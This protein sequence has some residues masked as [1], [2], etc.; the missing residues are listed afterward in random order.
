MRRFLALYINEMIKLTHRVLTL[1]GLAALVLVTL[2]VFLV[3][4]NSNGG[5]TD[6]DVSSTA[7]L[8]YANLQLAAIEAEFEQMSNEGIDEPT[9]YDPW[10]WIMRERARLKVERAR[11]LRD[12]DPGQFKYVYILKL[13]DGYSLNSAAIHVYNELEDLSAEDAMMR[14][15]MTHTLAYVGAASA[16]ELE[17]RALTAEKALDDGTF[18][19]YLDYNFLFDSGSDFGRSELRAVYQEIWEAAEVD[20]AI[21]KDQDRFEMLERRIS[22]Y[23]VRINGLMFG[24]DERGW[25]SVPLW[26]L[27][28]PQF[29]VERDVLRYQIENPN[30]LDAQN[31]FTDI[32]DMT[33]AGQTY[34]GA[35]ISMYFVLFIG[36]MILSASSLSQEIETGTI[37]A[38]ILSPVKRYKIVLAKLFALLTLAFALG[39]LT[40]FCMQ[41][42]S[43]ILFGPSSLPALV[44]GFGN[45]IF[46]IAQPFAAI[47]QFLFAFVQLTVF[48]VAALTL[49][50]V[51][52]HTATAVGLSLGLFFMS[53]VAQFIL[54]DS[55]F[56]ETL[57][58]LP[59][60]HVDFSGRIGL[61]LVSVISGLG[62]SS[63]YQMISWK[64]SAI[65][66][67]VLNGLLLWICFDSF[68]RRDI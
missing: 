42:F 11:A 46:S 21:R 54:A 28:E 36:M 14:D 16:S 57:R 43:L 40:I 8:D 60:Y 35:F 49:S 55:R 29:R 66:V 12:S 10:S 2:F 20:E 17:T 33:I 30:Y 19:S 41:A 68:V 58:L 65:Y 6:A 18:E 27:A 26:P 22:D 25:N 15:Y 34:T 13:L 44:L 50:A 64:M 48:I 7:D 38:L 23:M 5:R 24:I 3:G 51:I 45:H 53:V 1:V 59:F 32:S 4:R 63:H 67:V 56:S 52:R 37:K 31:G 61:S 62:L 39:L 9:P 47:V